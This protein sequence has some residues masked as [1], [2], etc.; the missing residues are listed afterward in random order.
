MADQKIFAGPR[1]RRIRKER[2]LTQT[3][4]ASGTHAI[5]AQTLRT[6]RR[7][8]GTRTASVAPVIPM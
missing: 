3:A 6:T 2:E 4:M 7:R 1:I 8:T 5:T